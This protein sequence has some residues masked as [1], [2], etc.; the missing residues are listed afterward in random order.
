[1]AAADPP[2]E[3]VTETER[4]AMRNLTI[5]YII[6][7]Y[8]EVNSLGR[9]AGALRHEL[10]RSGVQVRP[11]TADHM[12]LP[13][14][15][16]HLL[17]RAG[18]DVAAFLRTYPLI[19]PKLQGDLVHLT[20]RTHA[21]L[22]VHKPSIPVVVTVHDIIHYQYRHEPQMHIYRHGIQSMF[23]AFAVKSLRRADAVIASSEYTRQALIDEVG[24]EAGRVHRIYLGVDHSRFRPV[25]VPDSFYEA[26]GLERAQRYIIH[27]STE[28]MRKDFALLLRA[29]ARISAD[30]P[31]VR[32]LKIGRPLYP[33][34]R[35]HHLELVRELGIADKVR[36]VDEVS[37]DDLVL[38]YNLGAALV[39]PSLAEGFGFPVLEAM[40]CGTPVICSTGGSLPEVAGDA[41]LLFP[42]RDLDALTAALRRL[43]SD[44]GLP[45][46]M[47]QRGLKNA[48]S[49]TWARTAEQTLRLYQQIV[50]ARQVATAGSGAR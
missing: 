42:P 48:A 45:E 14:S 31:D 1:M 12:P 18:L 30:H 41:A 33:H 26:R 43:L 8:N 25:T 27:V 20:Q 19:M 9:Y 2:L 6:Q 34:M 4:H 38:Y 23:D 11:V 50:Q 28:E 37:D 10:E 49:F 13:S 3:L 22:L 32:L 15:I 16:V 24:L 21:T 7:H 35:A 44:A 5:D 36:F 47:R 29:F 46:Q 17:K 40:A 39:L